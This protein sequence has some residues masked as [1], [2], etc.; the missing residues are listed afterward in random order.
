MAWDR[1]KLY[2]MLTITGS[3]KNGDKSIYF[4]GEIVGAITESHDGWCVWKIT[5]LCDVEDPSE[6]CLYKDRME[7]LGDFDTITE[8]E[9]YVKGHFAMQILKDGNLVH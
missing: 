5:E 2:N 7:H 1:L 3:S 6:V 9:T 8:A 4:N